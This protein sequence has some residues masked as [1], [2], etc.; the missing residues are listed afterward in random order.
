MHQKCI[1]N[2]L[3]RLHDASKRLP[4]RLQD[5]PRRILPPFWAATWDHLGHLFPPKTASR[6]PG[7][8][9]KASLGVS[10][11]VLGACWGLMAAKSQQER[12][13]GP[14]WPNFPPFLGGLL[15]D[16]GSMFAR[17][18]LIFLGRFL[19]D[20][21]IIFLSIFD[22]LVAGLKQDFNRI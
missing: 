13:L 12:L 21:Y 7:R 2:A 3:N 22:G 19:V 20:F 18:S 8:L 11:D 5:G 17:C 6:S 4:R 14:S 10:W 9:Q 15:L 1:K 16:F